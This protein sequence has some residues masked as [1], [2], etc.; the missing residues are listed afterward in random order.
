MLLQLE[1]SKEHRQFLDPASLHDEELQP[2]SVRLDPSN[3]I[4]TYV[5]TIAGD[6]SSATDAN[7]SSS[8]TKSEGLAES[9]LKVGHV[10][11]LLL[12]DDAPSNRT[13]LSLMLLGKGFTCRE[14]TNGLEAVEMY[15]AH[16]IG[17]DTVDQMKDG[18]CKSVHST[19][20]ATESFYDAI[21]VDF[22]MP[23]MNG[24]TTVRELRALGCTSLVVG[25]TGNLLAED[26]EV[27]RSSGA[28]V[29]LAK[30]FEFEQFKS[31]WDTRRAPSTPVVTESSPTLESQGVLSPAVQCSE[32]DTAKV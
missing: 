3:T 17:V 30:P 8:E 7:E 9:R 16:G 15:R 20:S 23:V 6:T 4:H 24:P 22:E 18:T 31:V 10:G 11:R 26:V 14:A 27:F 5:T 32:I 2:I 12:V 1:H 13:M 25:L 19:S 29:V 21:L 28:D